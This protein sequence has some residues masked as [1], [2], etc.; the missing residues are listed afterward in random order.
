MEPSAE[1]LARELAQSN[2]I[3]NGPVKAQG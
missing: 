2:L 1:R 3:N